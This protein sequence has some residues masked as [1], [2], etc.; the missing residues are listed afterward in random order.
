MKQQMREIASLLSES[1]PKEEKARIRAEAL[2][3]DDNMIEAYEILQLNCELLSERV[4]FINSEK[5]CPEDLKSCI[6]TLI[7]SCE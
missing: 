1:P 6:T 3:R 2:I 7:W 5:S 4:N